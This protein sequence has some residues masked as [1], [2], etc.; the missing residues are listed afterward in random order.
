METKHQNGRCKVPPLA[1]WPRVSVCGF[2]R[3]SL[4]G[5]LSLSRSSSQFLSLSA[6]IS[7][8][9]ACFFEF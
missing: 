2:D 5:T 3:F 6:S 4:N 8:F 9:A 7:L 1:E